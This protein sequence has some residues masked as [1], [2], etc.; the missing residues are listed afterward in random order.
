MHNCFV[1]TY[2]LAVSQSACIFHPG[3]H[4]AAPKNKVNVGLLSG[5]LGLLLLIIVGAVIL[6]TGSWLCIHHKRKNSKA[7]T[8]KCIIL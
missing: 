5:L 3:V 7:T 4:V 6:G 1:I 2:S 8:G